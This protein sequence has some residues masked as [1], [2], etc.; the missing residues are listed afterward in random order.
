MPMQLGD[1]ESTYADTSKLKDWIN[2]SPKTSVK[3]GVSNFVDW[4][5]N[6]YKIE[7]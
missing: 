7:N 2:Y 6:Y 1:V 4:F 5:K 3:E